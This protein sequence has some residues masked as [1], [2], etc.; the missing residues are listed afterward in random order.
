MKNRWLAGAV[1]V[2][3]LGGA[4]AEP[5]E[6]RFRA[7]TIDASIEI[8][9]GVTV[10]DVDGDGRP[11][12]LLADK[13]RVLW[14]RNPDWERF[15]MAENLTVHDHVCIA[16]EDITEDGRAEVAVGAEW[17]PGDT[18]TSGAVF[19]LLPPEDR[20]QRWTP[21]R[22]PHE[23]TVHRMRWIRGADGRHELVVVPLHGRGN[24]RGEGE[25]VRILSYRM[26]GDPRAVWPTEL[27]DG[28]LH[29]THNFDVIERGPTRP[30]DLLV[31]AREGVFHFS[32]GGDGWTRRQLA[33]DTGPASGFAGAGEV[34]HGRGFIATIEPMHGHQL[35]VY[36]PPRSDDPAVPWRRQ[37]LTEDL[38]DGH[39]LACGDLLGI[40]NDQI[41]AGWRAM[42]RPGTRVGIRLFT[43]LNAERTRWRESVIDDNTM[44]CEDLCLADLNGNGRLDVVAAGR[45]TRNL[46]IYFNDPA[47]TPGPQ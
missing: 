4:G 23:P 26:P 12:I 30:A 36:H 27:I 9:Y 10:A 1:L 45:A 35:V 44:A 7:V 2:A 8:G 24:V 5:P 46:M 28:S 37:V 21:V 17:N 31:A 29:L 38:I 14:Y 25:G 47:T 43:P 20:T 6:P 34:R 39:A 18:V 19:Y 3:G 32:R 11:D 13:R 40:G 15:V 33:G 41:V 16:A 22:L 42:N